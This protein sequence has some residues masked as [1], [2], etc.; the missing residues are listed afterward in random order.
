[1][2]PS[3]LSC[4]ALAVALATT[5]A[6]A[7]G[8]LMDHETDFCALR[9]Y[10]AAHLKAHPDQTVS[11]LAIFALKGWNISTGRDLPYSEPTI[12]LSVTANG[13]LF[14]PQ[15]LFCTDYDEDLPE[16]QRAPRAH[17]CRTVCGKGALRLTVDGDTLTVK[18]FD[19]PAQCDLPALDGRGDRTFVLKRTA[20]SEC[21]VPPTWPRDEAGME[22]LRRAHR[23]TFGIE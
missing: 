19:F 5:P 23:A 8:G 14:D 13:R 17:Y 6:G 16:A 15:P 18:A 20:M 1:M 21:A 4:A 12:G 7:A 10:G 3:R 11:G 22:A 9:A 2:R